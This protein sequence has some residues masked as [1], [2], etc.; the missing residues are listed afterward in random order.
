MSTA[1]VAPIP[2]VRSS[3]CERS[4]EPSG[5][6]VTALGSDVPEGGGEPGLLEGG[7]GFGHRAVFGVDVEGAPR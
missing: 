6:A 5:W 3:G 2:A 1:T 7:V 4:G